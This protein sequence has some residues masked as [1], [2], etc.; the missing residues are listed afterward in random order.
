M[1]SVWWLIPAIIAG[2]IIGMFL[3]ALLT[4]GGDRHE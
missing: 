4:V 1:I 2:A 3:I